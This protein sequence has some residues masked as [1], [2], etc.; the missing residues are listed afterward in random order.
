MPLHQFSWRPSMGETG[1][2]RDALYLIRPDGHVGLADAGADPDQL[3]R[4]LTR[5]GLRPAA[6]VTPDEPFADGD[7]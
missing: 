5:I 7:P 6:T 3:R 2:Q 1:L 4:Y